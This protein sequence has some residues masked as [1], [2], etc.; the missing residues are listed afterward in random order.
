VFFHYSYGVKFLYLVF[1]GILLLLLGDLLLI[2]V[3]LGVGGEAVPQGIKH[4]VHVPMSIYLSWISVASIAALASAIN[5]VVPGIPV[6]TQA[7]TT[8]VM[9]VVAL[10]LA[11][12]M[13]WMKRD[14]VFALVVIWAVMGISTKQA[15]IPIIYMTALA[16]STLAAAA[17]LLTPVFRKMNW[18]QYYLS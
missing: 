6:E 17:M 14:I 10:S 9:L 5:V 18:V 16:V 2:Y 8:A 4:A 3:R 15:G 12:L 13:L 1:T 7:T 11:G